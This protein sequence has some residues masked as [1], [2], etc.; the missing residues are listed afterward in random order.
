M[1]LEVLV[2]TNDFSTP[3][4]S[5]DVLSYA[6]HRPFD[7]SPQNHQEVH[8]SFFSSFTRSASSLPT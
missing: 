1:K 7:I 2:L 5:V 4:S 8:Q 3:A 6:T